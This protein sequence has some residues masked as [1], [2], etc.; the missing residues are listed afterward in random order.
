[1]ALAL[2]GALIILLV[3]IHELAGLL[4]WELHYSFHSKETLFFTYRSSGISA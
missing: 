1:M 2:L 4:I 3:A